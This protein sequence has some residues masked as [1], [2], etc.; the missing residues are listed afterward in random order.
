MVVAFGYAAVRYLGL[1]NM[2]ELHGT[3][4]VALII[5]AFMLVCAYAAFEAWRD[6]FAIESHIRINHVW[7]WIVRAVLV[8]CMWGI[9]A[10]KIGYSA[11]PYAI[12]S[13]FLFS[14]VFRYC[15]NK[16]R[17]KDWRYVAL[18]PESE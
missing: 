14:A 12:G 1:W 6:Y 13:A 18:P 7:S 4:E 16:L 8:S 9:A 15:L 2:D 5:G 10:V 17:G 11:I 3:M